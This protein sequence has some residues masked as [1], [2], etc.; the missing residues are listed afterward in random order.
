MH[1]ATEP[2]HVAQ[3]DVHSSHTRSKPMNLSLH[4]VAHLSPCRKKPSPHFVHVVVVPEHSSQ[5]LSHAWQTL[6]IDVKWLGHS[7]MHDSLY[8]DLGSLQDVHF[9]E[10]STHV[11]QLDEQM[12][13]F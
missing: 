10:L 5:L 7:S 12:S 8:S 2:S 11:L 4:F 6:E 9:I 1:V 3:F 13:H